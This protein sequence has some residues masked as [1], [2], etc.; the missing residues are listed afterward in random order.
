[1]T[2]EKKYRQKGNDYTRIISSNYEDINPENWHEQTLTDLGFD[3]DKL[4]FDQNGS[5]NLFKDQVGSIS[6]RD[7]KH[8][9]EIAEHIYINCFEGSSNFIIAPSLKSHT[10]LYLFD[11]EKRRILVIAYEKKAIG[12]ANFVTLYSRNNY[13]A[14]ESLYESGLIQDPETLE[15]IISI[16]ESLKELEQ[17]RN[18]T[19]KQPKTQ[20]DIRA[21]RAVQNSYRKRG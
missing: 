10:E 5:S 18:E 20:T 15:K 11:L 3:I 21:A 4:Q 14:Y 9:K 1:M 2:I 8:Y 17:Y 7:K 13:L 6:A 12:V 19:A 16:V